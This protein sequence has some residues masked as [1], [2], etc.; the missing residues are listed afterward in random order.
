M[1]KRNPVIFFFLKALLVYALLAFPS[2]L[3][4]GYEKFYRSVSR[5]FLSTVRGTGFCVFESKNDISDTEII[6]GNKT[7]LDEN[8]RTRT[9]NIP[10]NSH[11]DGYLP[12][13]LLLSLILASP[14]PVRRKGRALIIGF[15][16]MTAFVLFKVWIRIMYTCD[17]NPWL[18]LTNP[19]NS[20]MKIVSFIKV[21][22]V[23]YGAPSLTLT[24]ILWLLIS[25]TKND[26]EAFH[27]TNFPIRNSG[28]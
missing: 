13:I 6:I 5:T 17:T 15:V 23:T 10:V 20:Q 18:Q 4:K 22:F 28:K 26:V 7:Q 1:L 12:T 19:S 16:L 21:N 11:Q 8:Q 27:Q 2:F 3:S 14:I 25:F 24:V 9:M